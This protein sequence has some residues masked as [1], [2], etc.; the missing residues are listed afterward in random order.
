MPVSLAAVNACVGFVALTKRSA[1]NYMKAAA[2]V[3]ALDLKNRRCAFRARSRSPQALC[4]WRP[5]E[6]D[7]THN[8]ALTTCQI[9]RHDADLNRQVPNRRRAP[10]RAEHANAAFAGIVLCRYWLATL[11]LAGQDPSQPVVAARARRRLRLGPVDQSSQ[12]GCVSYQG[13]ECQPSGPR[14]VSRGR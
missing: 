8:C 12:S 3:A 9:G 6:V 13:P 5:G 10:H 4:E 11:S 14:Q 2:W 7:R 1:Q